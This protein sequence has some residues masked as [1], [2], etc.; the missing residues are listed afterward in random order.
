[1]QQLS[2]QDLGN[3][4]FLFNL[5]SEEAWDDWAESVEDDD[6]N[7]ALELLQAVAASRKKMHQEL[8]MMLG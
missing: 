1:M 5:D 7:Y 6:L 2:E 8:D 3:L 4:S